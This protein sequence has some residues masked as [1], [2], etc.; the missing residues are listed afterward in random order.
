M[1]KM[2]LLGEMRRGAAVQRLCRGEIAAEGLLHD[3]PG[4]LAADRERRGLGDHGEHA[5]GMAM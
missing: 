2:A 3:H 5:R 4:L 1:R